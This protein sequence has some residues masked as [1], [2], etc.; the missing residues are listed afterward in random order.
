[1]RATL[2]AFARLRYRE[3]MGKA[4][5]TGLLILAASFVVAAAHAQEAADAPPLGISGEVRF[6]ADFELGPFTGRNDTLQG[7]VRYAPD[8]GSA[9]GEACV[10]LDAW[11]TGNALRDADARGV[12][13]VSA[14]P[15][16]CFEI[17]GID[18]EAGGAVT[19]SGTLDLHGVQRDL[20][21]DG[22]LVREGDGFAFEGGFETRFSA[23]EL[24]RP[25][26]LWMQVDDPVQ[27]EVEGRAMP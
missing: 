3:G 23:W 6:T 18:G 17:E 12:F 19:L 21:V 14:F 5:V 15:R 25:S 4:I 26:F 8:A 11:R 9:S 7:T 20:R 22:E 16:A 1:M 13:E 10:E 2:V 27:V 24:D